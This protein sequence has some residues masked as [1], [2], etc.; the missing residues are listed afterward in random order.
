MSMI[1]VFVGTNTHRE[2]IMVDSGVTIASVLSEQGIN[3]NVGTVALNGSTLP[4]HEYDMTF[5]DKGIVGGSAYLISSV[6]ADNAAT[7]QIAGG[8][9]VI[10][11]SAKPEQLKTMK[12]Y[13]PEVLTRYEGEGQNKK[14]VFA[15]GYTDNGYGSINAN[16]AVFSGRTNSEGKA[17]ITIQ[18]P[19]DVENPK[20]WAEE[21]LGVSILHLNKIEEA[22]AAK[23]TEIEA[24]KKSI[25]DAITVA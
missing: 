19:A 2:E 14:P 22:F 17:T 11:S 6:K 25:S 1:R 4:V 23:L 16:G 12:K 3:T 10:V 13:R 5:E 24:E 18:I 8:S 7:A 21:Y 20:A 9:L 15:I